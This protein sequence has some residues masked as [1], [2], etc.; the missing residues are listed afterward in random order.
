MVRAK[1]NFEAKRPEDTTRIRGGGGV[2]GGGGR[3]IGNCADRE[4][5]VGRHRTASRNHSR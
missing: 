1:A 2:F 5:T 3:R 4:W